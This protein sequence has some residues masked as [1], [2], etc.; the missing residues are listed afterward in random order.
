MGV[1]QSHEGDYR[2]DWKFKYTAINICA[3]LA[4]QLS[5]EIEGS[6]I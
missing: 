1:K 4:P 5:Y 6:F 3:N 2:Q